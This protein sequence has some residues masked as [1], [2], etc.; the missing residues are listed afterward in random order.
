M[1]KRTV[2]TFEMAQ[3]QFDYVAELLGLDETVRQMLRWPLR[4]YRF[5]VPVRMDDGS[6]RVFFGYRVQHND[7]R[8][9]AKG[10]IRFHPAETIDTIRA[11]AMWMTWKT[12]VAN[13]PLGGGKGGVAVDPASLSKTEL[14]RLCRGWI[15]HIWRNIGPRIDVPAPDVGT[16][17]QMMGWM[18][19]EYSKLVGEYTP[20]VITGKPVNGGGSLGRTEA[21]GYGVIYQIR[22]AMK[23]LKIDPS[24]SVAAIQ[25][26]GNVAQHTA[27]GF[28]EILGGKVACVS[29]WDRTDR[30]AYTVSHP[31]GIDPH[32]LISITDTYG[33]IDKDKA[34]EAGYLIEEGMAWLKKDVDVLIPAALEGQITGETVHW[35]SDRVKILAEGANGPTTPEADEVL[36][37]DR[38]DI[39]VI[40]D[41]LCNAGGVTVSYFESVQNDMNYYWPREEV[42][43]RLDAKMTEAFHGVYRLSAEER[44]YMRD[45]AYMVA[46]DRVVKAMEVRGWI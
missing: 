18:M 45:A 4:E 22:E 17:P 44:V 34:R 9:P 41:F 40:P 38:K 12:A 20:G 35:I 21:T 16:T 8:G 39:F 14:E 13:I 6:V 3:Q 42:L 24:Q 32:F 30:T 1:R 31:D 36:R 7:A 11:L 26:F 15:D 2:N 27:I 19:D 29:Y 37:K 23:L 46:I 43:E 25:G 10:G 28:T 33:T 5:Q